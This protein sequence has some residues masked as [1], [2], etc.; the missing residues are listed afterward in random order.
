[1]IPIKKR[2]KKRKTSADKR[3]EVIR[4]EVNEAFDKYKE[5][6]T[7]ENREKLQSAKKSLAEAYET[8]EAEELDLLIKQ[9][10]TAEERSRHEAS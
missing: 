5:Q 4:N 9:V 7:D 3:V 6:P 1:M 2:I 10:E 8:I